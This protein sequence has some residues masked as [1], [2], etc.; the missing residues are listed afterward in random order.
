MRTITLAL[1]AVLT[2]SEPVPIT[3]LDEC[4]QTRFLDT[5]RFGMKRILPMEYHGIRTFEPENAAE[6]AVVAQLAVEKYDVAF[7]LAGRGIL[8]A[9]PLIDPRR[10]RMQGPAFITRQ[11]VEQFPQPDALLTASREALAAFDE[12]RSQDIRLPGWTVVARPIRASKENCVRCHSASSGQ[13]L[14]IGDPLGVAV[15]VYRR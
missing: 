11:R 7:Y 14:K 9:P 4:I 13:T 6:K 12:G 2:G 5:G 15:Y 1:L 3:R 8:S 10:T